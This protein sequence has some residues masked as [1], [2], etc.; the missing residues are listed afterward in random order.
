MYFNSLNIEQ[1]ELSDILKV[2]RDSQTLASINVDYP[3]PAPNAVGPLRTRPDELSLNGHGPAQYLRNADAWSSPAFVKGKR[4]SSGSFFD[5]SLD[6]FADDDGF[7]VGKGRK[8]TKFARH[9]DSWRLLDRTPSPE[10]DTAERQLDGFEGSAEEAAL[11]APPQTVA[12]EIEIEV[13]DEAPGERRQL[14]PAPGSASVAYDEENLPQSLPESSSTDVGPHTLGALHSSYVVSHQ[15]GQMQPPATP[16][17]KPT[18][19]FGMTNNFELSRNARS[20]ERS[21]LETPRLGPLPSPWLPIV[22]PLIRHSG[23]STS[24]FPDSWNRLS[25]L[26]ASG[27]H[28]QPVTTPEAR[29]ASNHP[30]APSPDVE[31]LS[32]PSPVES[33]MMRATESEVAARDA[34][35]EAN[36]P[37]ID[38]SQNFDQS[39]Q[40]MPGASSYEE[41]RQPRPLPLERAQP[42]MDDS[43]SDL[44]FLNTS[45]VEPLNS[46]QSIGSHWGNL[47]DTMAT[48]QSPIESSLLTSADMLVS[49]SELPHEM[50]EKIS[51]FDAQTLYTPHEEA[52][53]ISTATHLGLALQQESVNAE[54]E[55]SLPQ[56]PIDP[57]FVNILESAAESITESEEYAEAPSKT[58]EQI[59]GPGLWTDKLNVSA[60]DAESQHVYTAPPFPFQQQWHR[61]PT[62][63]RSRRSSNYALLDGASEEIPDDESSD[64]E[65]ISDSSQPLE[66]IDLEN[67]RHDAVETNNDVRVSSPAPSPSRDDEKRQQSAQMSSEDEKVSNLKALDGSQRA[68]DLD[69][70]NEDATSSERSANMVKKAIPS[71]ALS[72][73][74][75]TPDLEASKVDGLGKVTGTNINEAQDLSTDNI[76]GR[77]LPPDSAHSS[78][79]TIDGVVAI[80]REGSQNEQMPIRR[81]ELTVAS[82]RP[83]TES[84]K[85]SSL[86]DE[87]LDKNLRNQLVTPENTQQ[88]GPDSQLQ[89]QTGKPGQEISLPPTPQNTQEDADVRP[90]AELPIEP[91]TKISIPQ[92]QKMPLPTSTDEV[93]ERRRSPRLSRKFPASQGVTEVVSPYFIPRRASQMWNQDQIVTRSVLTAIKPSQALASDASQ[94]TEEQNK[95]TDVSMT[96]EEFRSGSEL[97][98]LPKTGL[99][100]SLSYYTLLSLLQDHFAQSVD[101]L[102][103]STTISAETQKAKSGP[104][105]W[106][107][108]L[109]LT[110]PSLQGNKAITI[111]IFRPYKNALPQVQR[112]HVIL[113]RSFKV[114]SQRRKCMLLSTESSAWAVFSFHKETGHEISDSDA[115]VVGPPVEYG[116]EEM[117]YAAELKKWWEVEGE[118]Q[119]PPEKNGVQTGKAM[120]ETE[121]G[122][123]GEITHVLRD[124]TIYQDNTEGG[125]QVG[126]PGTYHELRDGTL[127]RD[128][129]V[130]R[131]FKSDR[132]SRES[133]ADKGE[134]AVSHELRNGTVYQDITP[135]PIQMD[136]KRSSNIGL[137]N[138]IL[139]V[140]DTDV[141][142]P[143]EDTEKDLELARFGA[144]HEAASSDESPANE[145]VSSQIYHELRN[146][147]RY[148]DPT[149]ARKQTGELL[150]QDGED[151]GESVIHELRDGVTYTDD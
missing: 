66:V 81:Q 28:E 97:P 119:Y 128:P 123:G 24:F 132:K 89:D 30:S 9:S 39:L 41:V 56:V 101:V 34:R 108:T 117:S 67:E 140:D 139:R 12:E 50:T 135:T 44:A 76:D 144:K 95:P 98:A 20:P 29:I 151:E 143:K 78:I 107:T 131:I 72:P 10:E 23:V 59:R 118:S 105:D 43:D 25:A 75:K 3:S 149:L 61:R 96:Q 102:A 94:M 21:D 54:S 148:A 116:S 80:G 57:S 93:T 86:S 133:E 137:R 109:H 115:V 92:T 31:Q 120:P 147:R 63:Q 2:K 15:A 100:T 71:I 4:L 62:S 124:G 87:V 70:S 5:A 16:L 37:I 73:T 19:L 58:L 18:S 130:E 40:P 6:P 49:P 22:S 110:D 48:L 104:R 82:S 26:D 111:Q 74:E 46:I 27:D 45:S 1:K 13:I 129:T 126:A 114:Q 65:D 145:E 150:Q 68:V 91:A 60:V 79:P 99:K 38:V 88:E 146:G 11:A 47:A 36:P 14:G 77:D 42:S 69:S 7:V 17:Q 127:Y 138:T 32:S 83:I 125:E 136:Q 53:P 113:L 55:K 51:Q 35:F 85:P 122:E 106:H 64:V 90:T 84:A 52:R 8:R 121:N 134:T 142:D 141:T 33:E 103:L 112:G